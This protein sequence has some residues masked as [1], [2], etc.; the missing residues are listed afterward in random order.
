ML[1][2]MAAYTRLKGHPKFREINIIVISIYNDQQV[3]EICRVSRISWDNFTSIIR[4]IAWH[5]R[6]YN[7]FN[8]RYFAADVTSHSLAASILTNFSSYYFRSLFERPFRDGVTCW[9]RHI[10]EVLE[11][12]INSWHIKG[13]NIAISGSTCWIEPSQVWSHTQG[14]II[15]VFDIWEEQFDSMNKNNIYKTS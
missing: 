15:S 13:Q 6:S 11:S 4:A 3:N 8:W 7:G 2:R 1:S 14:F 5:V 12:N 9:E 10:G